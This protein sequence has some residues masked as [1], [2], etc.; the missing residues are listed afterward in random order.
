MEGSLHRFR[1]GRSDAPPARA[2]KRGAETS[3][4]TRCRH[5]KRKCVRTEEGCRLCSTASVQCSFSKG[6]QVAPLDNQGGGQ[7]KEMASWLSVCLNET[8]PTSM[9]SVEWMNLSS[10]EPRDVDPRF[11]SPSTA[12]GLRETP[13]DEGYWTEKSVPVLGDSSPQIRNILSPRNSRTF[14]IATTPTQSIVLLK[15]R[16]PPAGRQLVDA[17]FR[18]IHRSY[19]FIDRAAVLKDVDAM[20]SL[21]DGFEKMSRKLFLIMAIGCTTLRRIGH[22]SDETFA[23]F[24]V[25]GPIIFQDCLSKNDIESIEELLLLV[26]YSFFDPGGLSP[27]IITA[28]LTRQIIAMGLTRKLSNNH[29]LTLSQVEARHRLYWSIYSLDRIV[30]LSTGL[31]LSLSDPY[32][33]VPLPGI[34]LEEYA[35]PDREYFTITLLVNRHIITLRQIESAI[36][37][38]IHFLN[39]LNPNIMNPDLN[40]RAIVANLRAKIEDW[41]TQGCLVNP[42]ER[43]NIPFHNTIPWLNCRYQNLLLLLYMPSTWNYSISNDHL[44]VLQGA[45]EKYVQLSKVLFQQRHLPLNWVT[46]CRLVAMCPML[47]YVLVRGGGEMAG[48][49][50]ESAISCAEILEAFNESWLL[51][52]KVASA[53]RLFEGMLDVPNPLSV[54]NT[55]TFLEN[56]NRTELNL[57]INEARKVIEEAMGRSSIYYGV[58]DAVLYAMSERGNDVMLSAWSAG[59]LPSQGFWMDDAA[60]WQDAGSSS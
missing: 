46:L 12:G 36:L 55:T 31:P 2:K 20:I 25:P 1:L 5:M 43:D 22:V 11:E 57:V 32:T 39:P 23:R 47:L 28:M 53:F 30:S 41:Y 27:S 9:T 49:V 24:K 52:K 60:I 17:Y 15:S 21:S 37:E 19:P 6:A 59:N 10:E 3:A 38:R 54:G 4:C 40:V 44:Y 56:R 7:F 14:A 34:S 48:S 18:H 26:L 8:S 42:L 29:K 58:L 45:A 33:N 16:E 13:A 35:S 51:A 50:K